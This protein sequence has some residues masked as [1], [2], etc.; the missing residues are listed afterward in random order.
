MIRNDNDMHSRTHKQPQR[1]NVIV[2][3]SWDALR[4]LP[5]VLGLLVATEKQ[6]HAYTD[7]GTGALIWQM[8]AAGFVGLMF[9]LRKFTGWF[10]AKKKE[11]KD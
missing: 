2:E 6:A 3:W 7:P 9:Y 8:V 4:A 11:T 10:K 1:Q 5:F